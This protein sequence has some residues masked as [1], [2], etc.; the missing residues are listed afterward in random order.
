MTQK[1]GTCPDQSATPR[2]ESVRITFLTQWFDPEPAQFRG[3]PLARELVRRGHEV[4]V[5]TGFPNYPTGEIYPGY[6]LRPW[7]RESM[8]GVDV[9]RVALYPSHDQK[10]LSRIANYASF[11]LS[12][13]ILGPL[14]TNATDVL[15]VY[16]PPPTVGTAAATFRWYRNVPVVYH[17]ADMWPESVLES[18]M[19]GDGIGK[20]IVGSILARYCDWVYTQ[21]DEITVLSPG[22][23]RLLVERGVAEEKV[24]VVY[25]WAD[26]AVFFPRDRDQSA[27]A[28]LGLA[29]RFNV[30]YAGN[31]GD[32]QGLDTIIN[33]AATLGDIPRIQ[34]VIAGTGVAEQRLKELANRLGL[35]NVL[36]LGHRSIDEMPAINALADVLL[37]HLRDLPFFRATVPGKT[38]VSLASGRP[39]LMGAAGDAADIVRRAHAGITV[40]PENP[41]ELA[42]AIRRLYHL[43]TSERE[44]MGRRGREYYLREMSLRAGADRMEEIFE[45]ARQGSANRP[46]A[47]GRTKWPHPLHPR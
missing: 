23:K 44:A 36:F 19:L 2:S 20:P 18:G 25:N 38:Q 37:V 21:C 9:L 11:A 30:V 12:S 41:R 24:H 32:F 43:P 47:N 35:T 34:I 46:H 14:L 5:I 45:S 6:Q 27:A 33:V 7:M 26:D 29:D 22:F 3:L 8:G 17:I 39:I 28:K 15:Y 1:T 13:A 40:Q 4:Q 10:A 42:E 16:H 31:V